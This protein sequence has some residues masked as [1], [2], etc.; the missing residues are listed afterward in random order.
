[1][2]SSRNDLP[3]AAKQSNSV[4]SFK[5]SIL[6]QNAVKKEPAKSMEDLPWIIEA[7][8]YNR[9]CQDSVTFHS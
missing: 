4:G 5:E 3:N 9:F 7:T 1:M 6:S 8:Q 2:D